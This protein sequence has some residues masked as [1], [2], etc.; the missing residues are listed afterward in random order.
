MAFEVWDA[1]TANLLGAYETE[2]DA[3]TVV[4]EAL[5]VHGAAY[6]KTLV[7]GQEDERGDSR[8][9]AAGQALVGLARQRMVGV[10]Q[11]SVPGSAEPAKMPS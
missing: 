10:N 6:V 8:T 11:R 3:L 5:Q 2:D 9:I 7:L 4:R 1:E